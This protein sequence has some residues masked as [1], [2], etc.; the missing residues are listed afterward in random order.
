MFLACFVFLFYRALVQSDAYIGF[1]GLVAVFSNI[2]CS[3]R[4]SNSTQTI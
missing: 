4:D 3:S 1:P 2:F